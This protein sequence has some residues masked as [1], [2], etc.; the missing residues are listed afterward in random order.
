MEQKIRAL[1][2]FQLMQVYLD[3]KAGQLNQT[4]QT[5]HSYSFAGNFGLQYTV[6]L[7]DVNSY[8][9]KCE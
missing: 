7:K 5:K 2:V 1:S 3:A 8:I 4:D 6:G 9:F